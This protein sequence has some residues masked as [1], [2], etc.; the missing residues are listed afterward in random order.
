ML[1]EEG[2]LI[3]WK[4]LLISNFKYF[5]ILLVFYIGKSWNAKRKF[6]FKYEFII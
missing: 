2:E 1:F 6:F 3:L 4:K 5:N